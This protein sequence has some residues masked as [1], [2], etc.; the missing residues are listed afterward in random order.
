MQPV[1][2]L[3]LATLGRDKELA[4]FLQSIVQQTISQELI[5]V[6]VVDQNTHVDISSIIKEYQNQINLKH[7]KSQ[8]KGLSYNRNLGMAEVRGQIIA[9]PDDDCCYYPDTLEKVLEVFENNSN[10]SLVLGRI[11][12]RTI[13]MN[14]IR[15]WSS[16]SK[17]ISKSNF[18]THYTSI[19]LFT[20]TRMSFD[21]R[22]GAGTYFGSY[23]DADY[24]YSVILREGSAVYDP[25][26]EVWHPD[27]SIYSYG[28]KT[29]VQYGLGFGALTRK[30]WSLV[31]AYLFVGVLSY[32]LFNLLKALVSGDRT[33]V[34]KR[35]LSITSRIRGFLEFPQSK[36]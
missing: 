6:I 2:S 26:I 36:E 9:F 4:D 30:H 17:A 7:F 21:E 34:R 31:F 32:H 28:E 33:E 13:G 3:V 18:F 19:T 15:E 27:R 10:T 11:F 1:F 23:E 20:K 22:L 24:T 14:I 29:I 16:K 25:S 12:D 8:K 35:C 5:E